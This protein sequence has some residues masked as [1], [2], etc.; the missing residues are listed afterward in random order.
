MNEFEKKLVEEL[1]SGSKKQGRYSL[2]PSKDTYCC[3]GVACDI[4]GLGVWDNDDYTI[5]G[6]DICNALLPH[7]V[8]L[9]LNWKTLDGMLDFLDKDL[10]SISLSSLNDIGFTFNQI[11]DII[12]ANLVIHN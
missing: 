7:E 6:G 3:L 2:K 5:I 4:S 10:T 12:E 8:R 11:A 1:R 9:K